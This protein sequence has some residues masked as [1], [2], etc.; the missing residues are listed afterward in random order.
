MEKSVNVTWLGH[1]CFRL[2]YGDWSL[3]VDPYQDGSVEGLGS[4]RCR[5]GAVYCSHGHHDHN[6]VGLVTLTGQTPPADFAV[7]TVEAAHND[8]G[9]AQRGPNTV[10][11]FSFGG[12]RVAHMGDLG[13]LPRGELLEKIRGCDLML[14]PIGGFFTIDCTVALEVVRL[15]APRAVV[16]MHYRTDKFGF[17]VLSTPDA[18]IAGF[19]ADRVTAAHGSSLTLTA[20]EPRGLVLLT[21]ALLL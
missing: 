20:L 4:V 17:E 7:E 9:G 8:C 19:P 1:A 3:V 2:E 6:A 16:P 5:A 18:F 13:H 21:P 12:L 14:L 10:H 11:I 15:A